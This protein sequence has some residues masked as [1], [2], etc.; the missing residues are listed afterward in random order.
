[1]LMAHRDV[2]D[3]LLHE[4]TTRAEAIRRDLARSHSADFAEQAQQRQNDE[5]LEALL[6]EA[7][8]GLLLVRQAQQRLAEGRYGEC[9]C[10]CE[11]IEAARLA[12][13]PVAE[14]CLRCAEDLGDHSSQAARLK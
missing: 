6:V 12:A 3:A 1:M 13:L 8:H 14:Y 4:Y 9:L 7:E 5:V 10:C 11:P 2:L